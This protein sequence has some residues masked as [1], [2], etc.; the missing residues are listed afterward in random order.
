MPSR[1]LILFLIK[2]LHLC[3]SIKEIVMVNW[4]WDYMILKISRIF[5]LEWN[6]SF[7]GLHGIRDY[8]IGDSQLPFSWVIL[9]PMINFAVYEIQIWLVACVILMRKNLRIQLHHTACMAHMYWKSYWR[10]KIIQESR[11]WVFILAGKIF[12]WTWNI[13][14]NMEC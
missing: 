8:M 13:L 1:Q 9:Q 5:V 6:S 2:I 4:I 11:Q 3:H 12:Y 7:C 14:M 10:K